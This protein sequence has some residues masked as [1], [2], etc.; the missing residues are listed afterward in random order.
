MRPSK[1]RVTALLA[2]VG[3]GLEVEIEELRLGLL[4]AEQENH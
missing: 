1:A 3:F 4:V 2:D